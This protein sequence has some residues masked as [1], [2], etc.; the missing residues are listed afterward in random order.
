MVIHRPTPIKF[1]LY[2]SCDISKTC[3]E[4]QCLQS[5]LVNKLTSVFQKVKK[6]THTLHTTHTTSGHETNFY[7]HHMKNKDDKNCDCMKDEK[8]INIILLINIWLFV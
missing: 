6:H 1:N 7:K 2:F 3:R 4:L 5:K 8:M